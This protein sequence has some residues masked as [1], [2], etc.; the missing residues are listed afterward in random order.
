MKAHGRGVTVIDITLMLCDSAQVYDGKLSILGGGWETIARQAP[1]AVAAIVT[2]PWDR[3]AGVL[4]W[5]LDIVDAD[6]QPW[7][8]DG[9]TPL[10]LQ[11]ELSFQRTEQVL[12]G[13]ELQVPL[14][15]NFGPLFSQTGRFSV[16]LDISGTMGTRSF[17]VI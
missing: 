14:A 10:A 16:R 12:P 2:I 13:T 11:G 4:Q 1:C 9:T 5:R 7:L 3:E 15:F 8:P 6:G 17:S